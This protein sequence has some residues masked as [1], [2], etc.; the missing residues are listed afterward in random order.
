MMEMELRSKFRKEQSGFGDGQNQSLP[1][2]ELGSNA[3]MYSLDSITGMSGSDS[4]IR[5][6]AEESCFKSKTNWKSSKG[7]MTVTGMSSADHLPVIDKSSRPEPAAGMVSVTYKP[8][9][10]MSSAAPLSIAELYRTNHMSVAG[11]SITD[12]V[13]AAGVSRLNNMKVAGM[14]SAS[15]LPVAG[16]SSTALM[17]VAGVS[18]A[19]QLPVVG[20]SKTVPISVPRESNMLPLSVG[21]RPVSNANQVRPGY[22]EVGIP[23][24][25]RTAGSF[26]S[27]NDRLSGNVQINREA[28]QYSEAEC[29]HRAHINPNSEV[30]GYIGTPESEFPSFEVPELQVPKFPEL[31]VP[32]FPELLSSQ[33][34]LLIFKLK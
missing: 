9:A 22:S 19:T 4:C 10:G 3:G 33:V 17:S 25:N 18:S 7:E 31:Q 1:M 26:A 5:T 16:I 27:N 11:M 32:K 6:V 20:M 23:E 8:V 12:P 30:P 2:A 29:Y 24:V 13:R 14:S 21:N 15:Q 28:L 34:K